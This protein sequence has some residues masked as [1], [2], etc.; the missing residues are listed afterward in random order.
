MITSADF[1][2]DVIKNDVFHRIFRWFTENSALNAIFVVWRWLTPHFVARL[3]F[4]NL[5][6]H[7]W[8]SLTAWLHLQTIFLPA[9]SKNGKNPGKIRHIAT[10]RRHHVRFWQTLQ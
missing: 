7:F 1:G 5:Q 6:I 10:I 8:A 9:Y 2:D 4:Y 3:L